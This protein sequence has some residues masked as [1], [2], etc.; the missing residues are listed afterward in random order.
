MSF[1]MVQVMDYLRRGEDM[2]VICFGP[3][4]EVSSDMWRSAT[5]TDPGD[6]QAHLQ[7][8]MYDAGANTSKHQ[9]WLDARATEQAKWSGTNSDTP[10][11]DNQGTTPSTSRQTPSAS[12][13][14][15]AGASV[16]PQTLTRKRRLSESLG[17]DAGADDEVANTDMGR[18]RWGAQYEGDQ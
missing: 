16:L 2:G 4:P 7:R 11:M 1:D 5:C 6:N 18:L 9:L 12:V 15:T 14:H 10:T 13:V 3:F 17:T 8:I